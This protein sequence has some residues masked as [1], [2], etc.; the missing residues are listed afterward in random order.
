M[1][2]CWNRCLEKRILKSTGSGPENVEQKWNNQKP[3]MERKEMINA[4][5]VIMEKRLQQTITIC[6]FLL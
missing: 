5:D 1:G 2:F 4:E 3:E 6:P